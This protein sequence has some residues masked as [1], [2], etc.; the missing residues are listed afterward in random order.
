PDGR[1]HADNFYLT[2]LQMAGAYGDYANAL[3]V[4]DGDA[5]QALRYNRIAEW[6][7][8]EGE[9]IPMLYQR[10]AILYALDDFDGAQ[11]IVNDLEGL[12]HARKDKQKQ[13]MNQLLQ[14]YCEVHQFN[15]AS[16]IKMLARKMVMKVS[17]GK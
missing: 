5:E 14:L 8:R 3:M 12:Y 10:A 4:F 16:C 9:K 1:Y 2:S 13:T 6:Y 7:M 17:P 15:T 11:A